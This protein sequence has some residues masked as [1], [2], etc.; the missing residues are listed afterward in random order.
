[1]KDSSGFGTICVIPSTGG[2]A[3]RKVEGL[4]RLPGVEVDHRLT[5]HPQRIE[6]TE[7]RNEVR[8]Q[9]R[10]SIGKSTGEINTDSTENFV[11]SIDAC[12]EC[13]FFF[14]RR[15][16]LNAKLVLEKLHIGSCTRRLQM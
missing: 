9:R 8:T 3:D 2:T 14:I 16:R 10:R 13:I 4:Q 12:V 11:C 7:T 15:H 6:A 5:G 1:M